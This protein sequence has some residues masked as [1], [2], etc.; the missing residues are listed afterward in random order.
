MRGLASFTFPL[1]CC[2]HWGTKV[3]SKEKEVTEQI[4]ME[5]LRGCSFLQYLAGFK[6]HVDLL[7]GLG[8]QKQRNT[9]Y[10]QMLPGFCNGGKCT[11]CQPKKRHCQV[12]FTHSK[13]LISCL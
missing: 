13:V 7:G 12:S 8:N 3:P 9:S 6:M 4:T 5:C 10:Q 2:C 1:V 11:P